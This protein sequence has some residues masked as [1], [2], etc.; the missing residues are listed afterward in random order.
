[1]PWRRA[2]EKRRWRLATTDLHTQRSLP[3]FFV[4]ILASLAAVRPS[5]HFFPSL[6][7]AKVSEGDL[8]GSG[9][10]GCQPIIYPCIVNAGPI[11]PASARMKL[12]ARCASFHVQILSAC[13][14][15]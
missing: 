8:P 14:H 1:M 7:V 2:V 12:I 10:Q 4:R 6:L 11:Y 5:G 13:Q 15:H 3:P 9:R